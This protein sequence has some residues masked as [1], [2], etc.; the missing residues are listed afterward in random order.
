MRC[1]VCNNQVHLNIKF[2][3]E[4]CDPCDEWKAK[5]CK[6]ETCRYCRDRP[7][8]PSMDKKK[9]DIRTGFV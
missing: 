4:Y 9:A 5:K 7:K 3:A 8:R 6:D 1:E 2:D